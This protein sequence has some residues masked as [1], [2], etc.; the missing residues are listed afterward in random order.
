MKLTSIFK[1]TLF[2]A[3]QYLTGWTPT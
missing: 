1:V 2:T 3:T